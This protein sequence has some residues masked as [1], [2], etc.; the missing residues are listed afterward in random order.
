RLY[1]PRAEPGTTISG[2]RNENLENLTYPDEQFD[3]I[4]TQDVLEHIANP[5]N[6]FREIARV[7]RPGGR[8]VFTIPWY[9]AAKTR[10]RALKKQG[11][12]VHLVEPERHGNPVD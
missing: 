7:L 11:R 5:S 2:Y 10:T 3:L 6:A 9:P 12:I 4:I 8:H 1:F